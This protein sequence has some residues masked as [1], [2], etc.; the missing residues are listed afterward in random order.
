MNNFDA[1]PGAEIDTTVVGGGVDYNFTSSTKA[2]GNLAMRK[3]EPNGG[4]DVDSTYLGFGMET[5]F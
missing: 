1:G 5:R 2:Y 4:S 3:D